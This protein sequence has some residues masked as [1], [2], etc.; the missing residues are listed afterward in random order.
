MRTF[1][2]KPFHTSASDMGL[3]ETIWIGSS[4]NDGETNLTEDWI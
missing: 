4:P 1:M 2:R 3:I